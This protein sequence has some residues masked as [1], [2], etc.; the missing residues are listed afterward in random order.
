MQNP[1]IDFIF[2]YENNRKHLYVKEFPKDPLR[3]IYVLLMMEDIN[4]EKYFF[5]LIIMNMEQVKKSLK[6]SLFVM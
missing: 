2:I 5:I 1:L 4:K 6:K 3:P